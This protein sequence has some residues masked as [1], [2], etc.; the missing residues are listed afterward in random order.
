MGQRALG[1]DKMLDAAQSLGF[2]VGSC[3]CAVL[4]AGFAVRTLQPGVVEWKPLPEGR[5]NPN[6][7]PAASLSRLPGIGPARARAIVNLRT[8]LRDRSEHQ[9]AFQ[10]AGDLGQV[11]GSGPATIKGIRPWLRFDPSATAGNELQ[12]D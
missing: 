3:V 9:P 12:G 6:E 7:A 11:E 8:S 2:L 5:I 10:N 4:A 1:H